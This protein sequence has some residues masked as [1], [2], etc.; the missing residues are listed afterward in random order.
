[1]PSLDVM[2]LVLAIRT[3]RQLDQES[4]T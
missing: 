1:M 2:Y 3:P 4:L